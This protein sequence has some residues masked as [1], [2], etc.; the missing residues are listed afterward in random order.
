MS[1]KNKTTKQEKIESS[2][3]KLNTKAVDRLV[4]ADK[5]TYQ[6]TKADPGKQYRSKG[7]LDKIPD[8]VKALFIKFWFN[9]AV[10]FFIGF[11]LSEFIHQDD[12]ILVL[13]LVIGMVTDILVNN[14][15]RFIA[16]TPDSNNKWMMFPQKK[17]WTFL[18]NMGYAVVITWL[19]AWIYSLLTMALM[20]MG[21][22]GGFGAEPISFGIFYV[23][24]D[25]AFIGIKNLIIKIINDAKEKANK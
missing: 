18:A 17:F 6:N 8:P 13:G 14:A 25:M 3:Y 10:Y 4:N 7:F 23:A 21:I 19:V 16:I 24:V 1:K 11:G 2:S 9:G 20:A 15:F 22:D 12:L 5:K